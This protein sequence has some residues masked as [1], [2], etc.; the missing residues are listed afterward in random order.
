VKPAY[1]I[2]GV[3]NDTKYRS[4]RE[5]P[6]PIF[7]LY[8]FGPNAYPEPFVLHVRSR[9]D[10]HAI[11][12]PVRH[13]L[14]S[15][16]SQLPVYQ[17]VTLTEDVDQSLWR[18]RLLVTLTSCFGAFALSASAIGLYGIL[19]YFVS[20]REREIGLRLALGANLQDV[21]WFV[22]RRVLPTLATGILAGAALCWLASTWI[23][24]L[25]YGVEPFDPATNIVAILFLM[26][27]G[28]GAAAVPAFR[29]VRV[30]PSSAL[31]RE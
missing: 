14:T 9:G 23:R 6:P 31:R 4:L 26:T 18:E 30:N 29:A 7:Y 5:V 19:A 10:P 25:L 15:I 16:D 27:I 21:I 22:V 17:V 11:I 28:I 13:V 3:V 24:S 2:I 12:E 20:R 8:D 1:E